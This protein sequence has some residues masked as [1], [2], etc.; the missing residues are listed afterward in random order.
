MTSRAA[1]IR[2]L[3]A[4]GMSPKEIRAA[5]VENLY[6]KPTYQ[7][8]NEALKPPRPPTGNKRGRPRTKVHMVDT[9]RELLAAYTKARARV[10]ITERMRNAFNILEAQ[11]EEYD[12]HEWRRNKDPLRY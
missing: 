5:C 10:T 1:Y 8:I 7:A 6:D 9:I 3:R 11:L 12:A 4:R 2:S